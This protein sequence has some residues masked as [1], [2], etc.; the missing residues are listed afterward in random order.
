MYRAELGLTGDG[1]VALGEPC[2]FAPGF[3]T[4][5]Y[6]DVGHGGAHDPRPRTYPAIVPDLPIEPASGGLPMMDSRMV[7]RV[8]LVLGS[9]LGAVESA[10]RS[11]SDQNA[12]DARDWRDGYAL[13]W[14]SAA[15]LVKIE[16]ARAM[17]AVLAAES[18]NGDGPGIGG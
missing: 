14:S 13:G 18:G 11:A 3:G 9:V 1:V 4:F 12:S 6:A 16:T 2:G 7:R 15:T 10:A 17:G 8:A 5:C